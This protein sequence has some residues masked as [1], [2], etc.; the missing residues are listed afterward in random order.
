MSILYTTTS[1]FT[2]YNYA[3]P[4][5]MC[6]LKVLITF[7]GHIKDIP[8]ILRR[9]CAK[10]KFECSIRHEKLMICKS[11]FSCLNCELKQEL[12]VISLTLCCCWVVGKTPNITGMN[13]YISIQLQQHLIIP[14]LLLG[15]Y[16]ATS[17][18][19]GIKLYTCPRANNQQQHH[20]HN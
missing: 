18:I 6:H 1:S 10:E 7:Y 4:Y 12:G 8:Q 9:P 13:I 2:L 3:H 5:K 16:I 19:T 11:A 20:N 15:C 14:V 17:K